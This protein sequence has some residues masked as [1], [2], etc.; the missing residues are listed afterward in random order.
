MSMERFIGFIDDASHH[1]CNLAS[2]AWV[3]YAPTR[4]LVT[5]RGACLGLETNNMVEYNAVIELLRDASL[6]DITCLEVRLDS[7]LVV[8]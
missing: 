4:Q 3:I 5:S 6:H 7:Q 2:V 1:T 8:S